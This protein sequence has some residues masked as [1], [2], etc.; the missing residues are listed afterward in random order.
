MDEKMSVDDLRANENPVSAKTSPSGSVSDT[1]RRRVLQAGAGL[2]AAAV[3]ASR[4]LAA[5]TIAGQSIIVPRAPN[6]VVIMT[7]APS[8]ALA[9][10]MG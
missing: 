1:T 7:R 6:I 8:Y 9:G 3:S 5:P 10:G 2:A 4:G